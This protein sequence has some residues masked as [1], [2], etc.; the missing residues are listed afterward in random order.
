[1]MKLPLRDF[2]WLTE[3][4]VKNFDINTVNLD[5]ETGYIIECDLHYPKKLHN[6]HANLPLAPEVLQINFENLSPYAKKSLLESDNKIKYSDVKLTATFNDRLDYVVHGKNL[7]LYLDLG[8]K[9][10]KIKRVLKFT[11]DTFI[12]TY[13]AKCT[14]ARQNSS[15]KFESNQFKKL[16]N[17]VYG[18]TMQNVRDYMVVKLHT[19]K[20]SALNA[21]A[22]HTYKSHS[23]LA[24]NL[25]QTNHFTPT[26]M[27]DSPMAIGV[28]ILELVS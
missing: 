23:I 19:T 15:T 2:Q 10:I 8:L 20:K 17:C 14:E 16:A 12:A 22:K 11:Q 28:S 24:E 7:K 18:K 4:E 21:I 26:V 13:I 25:V 3:D 5:G 27:H 1:M 9:L 6:K